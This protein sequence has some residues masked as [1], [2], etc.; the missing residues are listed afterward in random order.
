MPTF[1]INDEGKVNSYGFRT[2]N[3]GIDLDRFN[4]NPVMLDQHY[5]STSAVVGKWNN[6]RIKGSQLL[7]D[8]EFDSEDEDASKLEGKVDRGFVKSCSMGISFNREFMKLAPDGTYE[9][10]ESELF[11][12]SIVAIPSNANSIRLYAADGELIPDKEVKLSLSTLITEIT[13][14][15]EKQMEKI[16]L[17]ATSLVALGLTVSPETSE[18]LNLAIGELSA[19]LKA[20]T[21]AKLALQ[22]KFTEQA[23]SQATALVDSAIVEGKLTADMK[24]SFVTMATNDFALASKLIGSMSGKK[25]LSEEVILTTGDGTVKTADDFEK[26]PLAA[27]LAFKTNHPEAY[28]NLWK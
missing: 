3:A 20:E 18:S 23:K 5:N 4:A 16:I 27:Q 1:V 22:N 24:E 7:A 28:K 8:S 12:V 2:L 26:L 11:E 10:T 21:E 17:S 13:N 9:L 19:K 15:T 25:S 14:N 6:I